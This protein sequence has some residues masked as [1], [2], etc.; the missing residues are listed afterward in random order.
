MLYIVQSHVGK[1]V[2]YFTFLLLIFTPAK[3][4]FNYEYLMEG[5]DAYD[6]CFHLQ[7]LHQ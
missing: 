7:T 3:T 5:I 4:L 6:E 2:G 1:I